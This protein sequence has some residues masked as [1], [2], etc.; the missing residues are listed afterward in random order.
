MKS[1]QG[2]HKELPGKRGRCGQCCDAA[3]QPFMARSHGKM[4]RWIW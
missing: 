1:R 4:Q 2:I 3:T